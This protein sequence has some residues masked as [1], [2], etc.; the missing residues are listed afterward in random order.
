VASLKPTIWTAFQPT[1]PTQYG[2]LPLNKVR[3]NAWAMQVATAAGFPPGWSYTNSVTRAESSP[4]TAA[5]PARQYWTNGTG[6]QTKWVKAVLTWSASDLTKVALYY[7]DDNEAT[8]VPLV[9]DGGLDHVI[10]LTYDGSG[11]L[12]AT[13]WGNV[14]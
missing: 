7:S 5:L 10:T 6:N 14:P 13:S 1:L 11:N 3:A 9:D 4:G 12:T 8:Y 2:E